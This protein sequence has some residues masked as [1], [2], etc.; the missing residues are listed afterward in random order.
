MIFDVGGWMDDI[1][2]W[3]SLCVKLKEAVSLICEAQTSIALA[4]C[5]WWISIVAVPAAASFF[6]LSLASGPHYTFEHQEGG[7]IVGHLFHTGVLCSCLNL[8]TVCLSSG[9]WF[10]WGCQLCLEVPPV[11]DFLFTDLQGSSVIFQSLSFSCLFEA[12]RML[13]KWMD[14]SK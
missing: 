6:Q 13:T 10:G 8:W 1:L 2:A 9:Y 12:V 14:E 3:V 5:S 4:A 11:H 7:S